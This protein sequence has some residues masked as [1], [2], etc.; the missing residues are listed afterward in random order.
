M[1]SFAN[2]PETFFLFSQPIPSANLGFVD[3]KASEL[4][5]T[6]RGRDYTIHQSP[7]VLASNREGGTTG[8]GRSP[9][10]P[11]IGHLTDT[12]P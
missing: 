5:I 4:D 11:I 12:L 6:I 8:A 9:C 1:P 2:I 7:A 3:P 10:S